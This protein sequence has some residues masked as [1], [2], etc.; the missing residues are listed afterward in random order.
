MGKILK[1]GD[2]VFFYDFDT[3]TIR[4][5]VVKSPTSSFGNYMCYQLNFPSNA[6]NLFEIN[7]NECSLSNDDA[8]AYAIKLLR[9]KAKEMFTVAEELALKADRWEGKI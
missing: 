2:N 4:Q 7:Q 9:K 3:D 8:K 6:E 5:L 1:P